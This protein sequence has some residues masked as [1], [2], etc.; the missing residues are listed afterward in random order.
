MCMTLPWQIKEL[1]YSFRE[2]EQQWEQADY[3]V[4]PLKATP[5]E[6]KSSLGDD[7]LSEIEP[8]ILRSSNSVNQQ[9]NQCSNSSRGNDSYHQTRNKREF[10]S[11]ESENNFVM[12]S[13]HDKKF[14]RKSDPPKIGRIGRGITKPV[15]AT[16]ALPNHK[17]ASRDQVQGFKERDS[18]KK[19]WSR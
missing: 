11:T 19:I 6:G 8:R 17:R 9:M 1:E 3:Y 5:N 12:T 15:L 18:K 2:Q 10:R 13:L 14:T 16:Q 4:D 7:Y